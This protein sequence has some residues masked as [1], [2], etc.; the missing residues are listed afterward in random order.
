MAKYYL[1]SSVLLLVT[2]IA[3]S[4]TVMN[5]NRSIKL[6]R[7]VNNVLVDRLNEIQLDVYA[8]Q[9]PREGWADDEK[10]QGGEI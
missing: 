6:Q 5:M 9:H 10:Y 3:F 7:H 4:V 2:S 1:V 8:L